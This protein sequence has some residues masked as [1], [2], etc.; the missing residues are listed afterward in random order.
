M[1]T[2]RPSACRSPAFSGQR[3]GANGYVAGRLGHEDQ[4]GEAPA[5]A[6]RMVGPAL[7]FP[8]AG[9]FHHAGTAAQLL[10]DLLETLFV[11]ALH[12]VFLIVG[13]VLRL[14]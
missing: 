3:R 6:D 13:V 4:I 10:H 9:A 11:A 1:Q 14:G 8:P 5:F 12:V 2:L 7:E